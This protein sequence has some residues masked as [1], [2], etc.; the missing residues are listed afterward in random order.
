MAPVTQKNPLRIKRSEW[1]IFASAPLANELNYRS[2]I[3]DG[4]PVRDSWSVVFGRFS[5]WLLHSLRTARRPDWET[6][7]AGCQICLQ[8]FR[9]VLYR[10]GNGSGRGW[11]WPSVLPAVINISDNTCH[12][13][14]AMDHFWCIINQL[15]CHTLCRS[16]TS[17]S[18][19]LGSTIS[20]HVISTFDGK[21]WL[22]IIIIV[23]VSCVLR[24]VSG[25]WCILNMQA[26]Q[27]LKGLKCII[28]KKL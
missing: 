16:V 15:S 14:H 11:R 24:G 2:I 8:F 10:Y 3:R 12:R 22:S 21:M 13:A 17:L 27:V 7:L 19:H 5:I 1:Q 23:I 28:V 26:L 6:I 18:L 20:S 25:N 9:S 4:D